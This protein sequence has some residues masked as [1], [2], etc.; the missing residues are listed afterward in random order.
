MEE[1]RV[2]TQR[3]ERLARAQVALEGL[4][5][6]DAFGE[7]YS[8]H[9]DIA[10]PIIERRALRKPPWRFTDDTNM[11]LSIVATLR[12]HDGINQEHLARSFA[13]RFDITRG[14]GPA[15]HYLLPAISAGA[16]W[17]E[18]TRSLF[19]GQGSFGNGAAM[20]VAPIGAYFVDDLDQV[21]EHARRSAEVTHAHPEAAAGAVAVALAAACAWRLGGSHPLP[22][23]R[24]FLDTIL[25][26]VPESEV[27]EK[28][29]VARELPVETTVQAAVTALG[30]GS[31]VSAQ[32][33]VP[34]VLWCAAHRL[35][36]FEEALWLT[37][38]G[39]GDVDTTCAMVGGIVASHTGVESIPA[40]W[41]SSRETLPDWHLQDDD[42]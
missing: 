14:Y 15:M 27:C 6:G 12:R 20:R 8:L 2:S 16:P 7:Q 11:A 32:D 26:L 40:E 24:D 28:I 1:Q 34:F 42:I 30:N 31:F 35:G 25:P 4:S 36:N 21:V 22:G 37:A 18:A 13:A 17:Q 38:S 10:G 3:D 39:L 41:L 29:Q 5:V 23:P 33:T 19:G 9:P